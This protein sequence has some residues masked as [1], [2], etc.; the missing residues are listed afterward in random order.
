MKFKSSLTAVKNACYFAAVLIAAA[1]QNTEGAL[2]GI[3]KARFFILIPVAVSIGMLEGDLSGLLYGA[4]AGALWDVCSPGLD[5]FRAL[6]LALTGFTAGILT[7]FRLREKVATQYLFC[8][9]SVAAYCAIDWFFTVS[10][11]VGD[12]GL[13]KL[14][15]FY[16]GSA[17]Y[18][19]L[20]SFVVFLA[21][22]ALRNAFSDSITLASKR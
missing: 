22:R 21:L 12:S 18:T 9:V 19:L 1:L 4:L 14:I 6:W 3:G 11:P 7:R 10:L 16:G 8:S 17:A 13:E 15:Y 2:P 5:G 20:F